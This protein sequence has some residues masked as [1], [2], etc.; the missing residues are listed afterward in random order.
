[1]HTHL[2]WLIVVSTA[3]AAGLVPTDARAQEANRIAG[4]F[5][6]N[7]AASMFGPDGGARRMVRT[8]EDRGDGLV[9]ATFE[10]VDAAGNLTFTQYVARHDGKEY[11]W[12]LRGAEGAGTIA[13]TRVD[14]Y[15]STWVVRVDGE[16]TARGESAITR[17]GQTYTQTSRGVASDALEV[18]QMFNRRR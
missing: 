11:P 4:T 8:Y 7:R 2:R 17:D 6:L 10:G 3:F 16:V 12:L 9:H 13:L 5:V 15:S 18:V 1:M 14:A